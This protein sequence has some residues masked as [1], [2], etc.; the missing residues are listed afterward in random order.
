MDGTDDG[1]HE[2]SSNHSIAAVRDHCRSRPTTGIASRWLGPTK[3]VTLS[4]NGSGRLL[5]DRSTGPAITGL[6][7]IAPA[8]AKAGQVRNVVMTGDWPESIR[9]IQRQ[10]DGDNL[11][12]YWRL[13]IVTRLNRLFPGGQRLAEN[14]LATRRRALAMPMPE[15]F[16]FLSRWILPGP[17]HPGFRMSGDFTQTNPA[18]VA[19]EPGVDHP[20][21]GAQ[22]VSPVFDWLDAARELGRLA[23]CRQ[24]VEK[25]VI[26]DDE[27]QRRARHALLMLLSL[28][29]GN[30]TA[31]VADFEKLFPLL[32]AQTPVGVAD[33]WPETL[34]AE[35]GVRE[36]IDRPGVMD[37][38]SF[39]YGQRTLSARPAGIDLWH[40]HIASIMGRAQLL[41]SSGTE[42]TPD[43]LDGNEGMD[44]GDECQVGN[45]ESGL[46]QCP[47][48]PPG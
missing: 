11:A 3:I 42:A 18:P 40:A 10:S 35:R 38:I 47:M 27:Y 21:S 20:E 33:Q 15:R 13:R 34:L 16:E 46:S 8:P 9:G 37:L 2:Q 25:A 44:P 29:Q 12:S 22:I 39:V 24:R 41:K 4:L 6:D 43:A 48:V 31:T 32:K 1:Q 19:I 17:D 30:Q 28:E 23:E 26:P 45:A 14:T 36:F 5:S 7:S